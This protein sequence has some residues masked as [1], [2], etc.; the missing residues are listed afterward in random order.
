[1]A[2]VLAFADPSL[3]DYM[4]TVPLHLLMKDPELEEVEGE[5]CE[6]EEEIDGEGGVSW[7]S[8]LKSCSVEVDWA[9]HV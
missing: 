9:L 8:W 4:R 7:F 3:L 1:M 2:G 6:E 5:V